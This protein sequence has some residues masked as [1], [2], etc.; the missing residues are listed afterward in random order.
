M[1]H[2]LVNDISQLTDS[3]VDSKL[4]DLSRKYFLTRNPELQSQIANLISIYKEEMYTRR[5]KAKLH[6]EENGDNDLDSLINIS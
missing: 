1:I 5:A 4:S 2:P 3:E 6:Q